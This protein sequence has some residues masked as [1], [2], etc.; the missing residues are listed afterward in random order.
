VGTD[1][2]DLSALLRTAG[3]SG[4]DPVGDHYITVQGA[5][6]G[7]QILFD[8]DG[9]GPSPQWPNYIIMLQG[10]TG[11]VTWSQL[12]GVSAAPPTASLS[13]AVS[14]AEGDSG[15]TPFTFTVTRSGPADAAATVNWQVHA[16]GANPASISDFVGATDH[17]PAG[18]VSFAAGETSKTVT[19]QVA[20]DTAAEPD[21]TFTLDLLS[22][23]GVVIGPQHS[24]T[25]TILNDDSATSGGGSGGGGSGQVLTSARYGDTLI[26]GAGDDTL[27]AGRGPDQLTGRQGLD[28]GDDQV[29][30]LG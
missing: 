16:A 30:L 12:S 18:Q 4:S 6:G 3:Y 17:L 19:V 27:N 8:H 10:V 2:L 9:P 13:G 15:A 29:G 11:P 14:A 5:N 23:S 22:A 1:K 25:G 20:G 7:T 24:A 21:E 28:G 26:G